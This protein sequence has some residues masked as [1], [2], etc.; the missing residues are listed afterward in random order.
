MKFDYRWIGDRP[1]LGRQVAA[2]I[3]LAQPVAG[4]E[5]GLDSVLTM[6]KLVVGIKSNEGIPRKPD[7]VRIRRRQLRGRGKMPIQRDTLY[8]YQSQPEPVLST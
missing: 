7:R 1:Q 8:S 3:R 6:P 2:E 5:T 4:Q